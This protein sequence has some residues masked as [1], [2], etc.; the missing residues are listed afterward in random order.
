MDITTIIKH[1]YLP[2]MG[3]KVE[4]YLNKLTFLYVYLAAFKWLQV[5]F[6]WQHQLGWGI[7]T[8]VYIANLNIWASMCLM[9]Q[10]LRQ[11][12]CFPWVSWHKL[13]LLQI[14]AIAT[15][16]ICIQASGIKEHHVRISTASMNWVEMFP[17]LQLVLTLWNGLLLRN[18]LEVQHYHSA[19]CILLFTCAKNS[20]KCW[21]VYFQPCAVLFT[22]KNSIK[23]EPFFYEN[24]I[25][26]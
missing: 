5:F 23:N 6:S 9:K 1:L 10:S 13:L 18:C 15:L 22:I 14:S 4:W 24:G 26:H 16:A 17:S 11:R 21:Y 12:D 8:I 20:E 2:K 3:N 25:C 19:V 7:I